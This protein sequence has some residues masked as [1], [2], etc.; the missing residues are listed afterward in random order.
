MDSNLPI[1]GLPPQAIALL[2]TIAGPESSGS[3]NVIYNGKKFDDYSDHPRI[4]VPI[5]SGP[6]AGKTSSAAGKYQF[7]KGTWD[8]YKNKLGLT[9]FSPSSQDQAAWALAQDAYK[10]KT[11]SD[12]TEALSSGDPKT[13]AGVSKA[14]SPIWTSLPGGIEQG[15]N[16]NKFVKSYTEALDTAGDGTGSSSAD[17]VNSMA[18]GSLAGVK[19]HLV[20]S[21][22]FVPPPF[23]GQQGNFQPLIDD[24]QPQQPAQAPSTSEAAPVL[25]PVAPA[26]QA[27]ADDVMKAWG[28]N[29]AGASDQ[30]AAAA[31]AGNPDD[32]LIKSWGLDKTDAAPA[33]GLAKATDVASGKGVADITIGDIGSGINNVVKSVATGVPIIGGLLNKADA[34]TNAL[35]APAVNP[36]LSDGNKLAGESFGERYNNSLAQLNG[37][38]ADY[39]KAHPIAN[40]VGNVVGGVAGTVPMIMAAPAAMGAGTGGL[41]GN[42]LAGAASGAVIG[43]ADSAI[44]SGGDLE[45]TKKGAELGGAFG[46]AGPAIG[47]ALGA[48]GNK[49]LDLFSG[50]SPAARNVQN[51]L[52]SIGMSV[53]EA[54]NA[55]AK[56]GPNATLADIDPALTQEAGGL[57]SV[58]GAPTSILKTAMADRGAGA[59][60]RIAQAVD[61]ALGPKPD[62][63]GILND[64]RQ[65]AGASEAASSQTAKDA[66]NATMGGAADPH[67]VLTDMVS[68]RSAAAQPLYEKAMQG[69]SMAP[70]EKQFEGAFSDATGAVS[71]ASKELAAAQQKQLLAAAEVSKAGN[72]VYASSGA[73]DASREAQAAVDA[74]QK[75]LA[76]AA[77]Q[78]EDVLGRLRQAQSDGSANAPGAVWNPRIQQF[79][80]EP[81]LKTGLAQGAKIQRLESLAEGKPF[82]PTEY[83]ITGTDEAG[84]PIV[85]S[86]P[87][88]RTLNVAKKGL[89]AMV[90]AAKDPTTGRLSEEGKAIDGVR[91]AFLTELD[92]IN[93]DYAAARQSWAGPTVTQEAFNK[94]LGI[95]SNRGGATGVN[96]TPGALKDFLSTASD[97][98]KEA[99]KTGARTAFQQQMQ[100]APDQAGKAAMLASKEA[101]QEKLAAILGPDEAKKL[102]DQ[103][104]FKYADPVGEAFSKGM[105]IFSNRQG[106]AG[107]EDTPD[108]VK[109][110]LSSA[111]DA[112]KQAAQ[113]GARQAI[114]QAL[115]SARQGD[116]S[117]AQSLFGKSTANRDKL[118]ALFPNSKDLFDTL[119]NEFTM[120]A[121]GQRVAQNSATAERQAIQ[122]KYAPK[123]SGANGMAEA[124]V[125]EAV[126]GG[127]GAVA[128]YLGRNA[129]NS[130]K[131]QFAE[132]SRNALTEGTARGLVATGPSQQAFLNQLA[133]AASTAK[134][135]AGITSAANIGTNLLFRAA[136]DE[137]RRRLPQV[138]VPVVPHRTLELTVRPKARQ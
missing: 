77:A 78:K 115:S 18:A 52:S 39:A 56:L 27:P 33:E 47:K 94:G 21:V 138:N 36:M 42:M 72:N 87:N 80:D 112:E 43:G 26:P 124:M 55:L 105:N 69:G 48:T 127:P 101:N 51:V 53:D 92:K 67:T 130:L 29:D 20:Q 6:N 49:L 119:A 135:S 82:N 41:A 123:P 83:A 46:A 23:S 136:S 35:I 74:A 3:Y 125:G 71:Q 19:P 63:V 86:V 117:A 96:T 134:G 60:D 30:P 5:K 104:N 11:G 68:Q 45:A 57:A 7:L 32:A 76:A 79:L 137:A 102:V 15:T 97:G 66:L 91:R 70:L 129:L 110:W 108:A 113:Q 118:E 61:S 24:Q 99:L 121:T 122:Q 90:A 22:G 59:D 31:P 16:E 14:L 34:A 106:T 65:R 109:G 88:M 9:D 17:A 103:L 84:N 62:A 64:I 93:P 12:L 4:D 8:E 126:G 128:G 13:I 131:T 116:L 114:D 120:K 37:A 54:K 75:N 2:N 132:G 44:R 1:A 50:T 58:G 95:F 38:D 40:T 100:T 73:L 89:D 10:A 98:E 133:R 81:I 107:V 111:S 28:L 25:A 85:G